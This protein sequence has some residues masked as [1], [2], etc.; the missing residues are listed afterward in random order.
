MAVSALALR[1][2]IAIT[3]AATLAVSVAGC[4]T[5]GFR[6]IYA[7]GTGVSERLAQ[8]NVAPIPGRVGQRIR[9]EL[10]YQTT[11]GAGA[12]EPSYRLEVAIRESVQSSLVEESGDSQAQTYTL[13]ASFRL[14]DLASQEVVLTGKSYSRA[15]FQ[16][17]NSVFTNVR[18]R[19]D[20]EN[21]AATTVGNEL[22]TRLESFLASRPA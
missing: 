1:K 10:I 19:Q 20:A 14:V 9:N 12:A 7:A 11:G 6:P 2:T 13:D 4:G 15:P 3:L 16:R 5:S 18:A 8:V 21:R 22:K 17:F